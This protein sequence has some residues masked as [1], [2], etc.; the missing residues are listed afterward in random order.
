MRVGDEKAYFD[1]YVFIKAFIA[2]ELFEFEEALKLLDKVIELSPYDSQPHGEKGN[3]LNMLQKP[4]EAL[5]EYKAA[6]DLSER[7]SSQSSSKA[8]ALRG[9]GYSYIELG[10]LSKAKQMYEESLKID[11][12]SDIAIQ[13]LENIKLLL[14][15]SIKK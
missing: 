9:M 1:Y 7:F 3:I 11:A 5:L 14:K 8:I 6:F 2:A 12:E 15:K 13:E 10:E 4:N